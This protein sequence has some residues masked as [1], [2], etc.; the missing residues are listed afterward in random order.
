MNGKAKS[1]PCEAQG[2]CAYLLI[3]KQL[4]C[5]AKRAA[6][7]HVISDVSISMITHITVFRTLDL[8]HSR[9]LGTS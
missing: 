6:R 9:T 8:I 4:P 1:T 3:S 7:I 2:S 5:D